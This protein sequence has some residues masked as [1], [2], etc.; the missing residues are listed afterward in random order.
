MPLDF[1]NLLSQDTCPSVYFLAATYSFSV[2]IPIRTIFLNTAIHFA[3]SI[4]LVILYQSSSFS[5]ITF[6]R[7][8]VKAMFIKADRDCFGFHLYSNRRYPYQPL[9]TAGSGTPV[10]YSCSSS[11]PIL[12]E[13]SVPA[14][15]T[16]R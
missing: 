7:C 14:L 9:V 8:V 4:S 16:F 11:F 10:G 2:I 5:A 12:A 3:Y 13:V 15:T 1:P 6:F